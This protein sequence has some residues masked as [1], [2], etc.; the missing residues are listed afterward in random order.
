VNTEKLRIA[1]KRH[2]SGDSLM[3]EMRVVLP[4]L[5]E[6]S[7]TSSIQATQ[8]KNGECMDY[9]LE[10]TETEKLRMENNEELLIVVTF[11]KTKQCFRRVGEKQLVVC[12]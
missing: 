11:E 4:E 9:Y 7:T 3:I 8:L 10:L 12:E 5:D 2:F 1:T 6:E